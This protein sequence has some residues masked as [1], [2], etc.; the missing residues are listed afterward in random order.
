ML[1]CLTLGT[2]FCTANAVDIPRPEYPRPQFER[3]DWVNLNG[4]WTFEMDFGSSG[5]QRGWTN[6]KGLSKKITVPF[7]PESELS[8]I[9][10]T[11][12]IPCVWYQRNINIPAEWNGKKILLHFGAAD[13]ETKVYVDGK[14]VGEHKGAG[15]SFNFDITSYVKAGQQANLM[16]R[17]YDNLRGG[18]QPG[19]KQCTALYSA[20]CSYTRVTGIW[21]TVWMEAVNEQ[22]LKN[23][24]AIPDIDQ[25]QLVVRPE[26]YNEGNNNTLTVEVKDGKKTVAKRTS[27]ASNQSTIVLPIKNAHLW[28]PEDPYL[29]DVKYTV[30]N[31]QGEVIDEVSS[32]MGMRKVHISGGYFYLNN[33]PYFQ[34]LVLDQGYYPDGIWTAPS[35]EALRQDI[36]MSKAVGFNG[37]RLHQK[38]FEERYYY[39]ADKLGYLT[40]GE[41]ASWVLNINNELAVRNFLTEW[42]EIV[43]RDRNHPSLV[44]WTPLNET[45]N[46][47]PGVY[48]RFVNDLYDLTKAIDPTRPINDASGDSHVKTDIWSV[49]DYTRE[50][51]K[52]I[53]NHTIKAGVEPYRNMKGKDFL[54]NYAGQPYM[55]DEFGGL[56]WIPKEERANSWGYGANIDTVEEFYSILEKEID[57]LKA[58]K[59]VVGFCYTQITDVEQEKNGI[60]YYNRKPKFDTARVKAIFEKIPS[61][62]E[63]PQDLSDWK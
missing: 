41:E 34:R 47:T 1:L 32:Y 56:P 49:H 13:Y 11:D 10:Y 46:A 21:Q 30:K 63:N 48:V 61:I 60:Y 31:A 55:V 25:Q 62:I 16:V 33:K 6:S 14:M 40:W 58:C 15:S 17:V 19:G 20:G 24:F 37:A 54:S 42:A 53:A 23:V 59:H 44:T 26:F 35:D 38:V 3:T 12:F 7:C 18:M 51:D 2:A 22:A 45:W 5:E 39:W 52:L 43:V 4:Q 9:G 28:S 29:Y 50:P 27:Q 36:E 8:G 57:A